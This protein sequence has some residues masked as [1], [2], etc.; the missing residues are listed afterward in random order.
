MDERLPDINNYIV[1]DP[2]AVASFPQGLDADDPN[3]LPGSTAR[4]SRN[5]GDCDCKWELIKGVLN[6]G[7]GGQQ[8]SYVATWKCPTSGAEVITT[9]YASANTPCP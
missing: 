1:P 3:F 8:H 5:V 2:P 4:A 9:K 7:T 6:C